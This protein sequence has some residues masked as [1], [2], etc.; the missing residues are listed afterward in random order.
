MFKK[1]KKLIVA[2]LVLVAALRFGQKKPPL[3]W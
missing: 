1:G 2:L 3:I